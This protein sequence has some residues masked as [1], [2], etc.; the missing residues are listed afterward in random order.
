MQWKI[1][2]CALEHRTT[3]EHL[4]IQTIFPVSGTCNGKKPFINN[5]APL[6]F[7]IVKTK[8]AKGDMDTDPYFLAT[9]GDG[10]RHMYKCT[11]PQKSVCARQ[12]QSSAVIGITAASHHHLVEEFQYRNADN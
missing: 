3:T 8:H 11:P 12:M 5:L 2:P 10:R 6:R 9:H 1:S 7:G 4:G